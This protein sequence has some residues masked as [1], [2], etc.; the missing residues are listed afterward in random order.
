MVIV[1]QPSN[2]SKREYLSWLNLLYYRTPAG[3]FPTVRYEI[4]LMNGVIYQRK[5]R[6]L[7]WFTDDARRVPVQ[8]R[9]VLPFFFGS[10]TLQLEKEE[11]G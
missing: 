9:V 5:G 11:T 2:N 8:I 1:L 7:V 10:V 3:V 4:F 6:V